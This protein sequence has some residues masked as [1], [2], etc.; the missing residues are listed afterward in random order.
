MKA[1]LLLFICSATTLFAQRDTLKINNDWRFEIEKNKITPTS[2]LTFRTLN[3]S[4]VVSIPHTWNVKDISQNHYGFAWYQ[5]KLNIPANFKNKRLKLV[6]GA[7]N[8]TSYF[9]INGKKIGENIGDGF[10]KITLD[11]S[12]YLI[13]G[14]ENILTVL[15][16]N[17]YGQHKI[18]YGSSF[19][20]PNDGGII[21]EAYIVQ[22][23]K[24]GAERLSSLPK[25][26][27]NDHS[28]DLDLNISFQ[29]QQNIQLEVS[30]TELN[31]PTKNTI[32]RKKITPVWKDNVAQTSVHLDKVNPWHFDFANLYRIEVEVLKNNKVIDHI[33]STTGFRN[34]E[35]KNGKLFL[36]GEDIKLMGIEWTAGSNPDIGFAESKKDI[37]EN[38][39]RMKDVNAILTR[40]HFQQDDYFYELCDRL[41]ILVQ[42]EIPLWG[43]ETP[44]SSLMDELAKKQLDAMI[45]N[46]RNHPSIFS[47]GVGNELQGRNPEMKKLI[48]GWL[49]YA[50]KLDPSRK[51]TYVSNTIA[52]SFKGDKNFTPDAGSLGDYINMN[53]YS[54]SWWPIPEA[55]LSNYLDKVHHTYP[56]MPFFISEFGLCEPNFRGGDERRIKDL[57]YHMGVYETKDYINGAIYFDLTDYRTHYPGTSVEGRFRQRV[58]GVYDFYGNPKPS[59]KVLREL[60]SPVEVQQTR[61]SSKGK[62]SVVM[63]GSKGLPQHTIKGYKLYLSDKE[64]NYRSFKSY[65]VP[66]IKPGEQKIIEIEDLYNGEGIITVERPNGF[67]V[68][69][70]NFYVPKD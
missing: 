35:L 27:I 63:F 61:Q 66:E 16:N 64:N 56:D 47:W 29:Q 10:N 41:G 3:S 38:V 31:Q 44:A 53:E 39:K 22:Y 13:P 49:D 9:Y 19:D 33:T 28:A 43:G 26:N 50:R 65:N 36:N 69:Q 8:H 4:E 25:L 57:I 48:Q 68:T 24:D 32:F 7:V 51:V 60:S 30:L 40:I 23:N 5:K 62:L 17:D 46:L 18:P 37:Y 20:W 45:G 1:V 15:V 21:R 34:I 58:H 52:E 67:V 14:K 55:E 54:G 42:A 59:M 2:E 6:F 11:V 70:K 12:D